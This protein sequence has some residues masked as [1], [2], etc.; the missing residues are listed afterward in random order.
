M[1]DI[2]KCEWYDCPNKEICYRYIAKDNEHI[3]SYFLENPKEDGE[4][5]YLYNLIK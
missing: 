2:T 3:Q 5:K 1:T 4:C